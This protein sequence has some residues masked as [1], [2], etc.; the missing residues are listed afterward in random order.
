GRPRLLFCH[1]GFHGL[2]CGSLSVNGNLEFQQGFGPLLQDVTAIPFNDIAAL[3]RDLAKGD[4]A[5]FI[6]EPIQ[7]K[8]VFLPDDA[9]LPAV[10]SLCRKHGALFVADEV[11]TGLG[12]TGKMFA[13]EH[14]NLEPDIL[15]IAKALSGGYV[16]CGAVLSRK[17]I[18]DKVFSSLDRCVVH[19]ST[20]S[21]NELGMAAGIATLHVLKEEA[22]VENA[23]RQGAALTT[24]LN[25]TLKQYEMFAEVRGKGLLLGMEF[26]APHSTMLKMGWNLLHGLDP[27][28]FCQAMLIPLIKDHRILAQVAGH[29]LDVIKLI[30]AL[31]LVDSDIDWLVTA[32]E[33]VV[34]RCHRFPGP[35]WEVGKG[36]A[37]NFAASHKRP[38]A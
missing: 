24:R 37:A 6:V 12:R 23:A 9:Y 10:Q 38:A 18:H 34:A 30:P 20:F 3:E 29:H 4:V 7:G 21:Q 8:G 25:Q 35:M 1:H 31:T 5:A 14:W 36:L 26:Q 2:T 13:C 27:S 32:F 22:I 28:L 33:D 16:P 17:A 11:Q 15:V 19:S